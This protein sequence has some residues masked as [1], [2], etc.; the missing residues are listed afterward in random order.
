[1]AD[2]PD[3][4]SQGERARLLPVLA[5]T[6]R[7]R[8]MASVFLSILPQI[9]P[10]AEEVFKTIGQRIGKRDVLETYTEICLKNGD[11]PKDRP[12]GLICI[13]NSK[14]RWTALVEV[15][16][17][18]SELDEAQVTKYLEIAKA[19]GIDA[20]ITISNQFVAR[21]EHSPVAVPKMLL[22]KVALFHWCWAELATHCEVLAYQKAVTDQEQAFL[23]TEL[24]RFLSHAATGVER[25]AQ[26][27]ASWKDLVTAVSNNEKLKKT[28]PAVEE[29]VACWFSEERDL[30]LH[31]SRKLGQR[32][33][34]RIER[35]LADDPSE[36]LRNG[37]HILVEEA[38]LRST[39]L[40]PDAAAAIDICADIKRKTLTVSMKLKAP[41]DRKSTKARVNWFTRSIK[42][43]DPR[44]LVRAHWPGSSASTQEYLAVVREKPEVLQ[45][46]NGD[47]APHSFEVLL[48]E[49]LGK[50]FAGRRTFVE[51][52]ER[53]VPEFYTTVG[54]HLR[55][56]Q[57]QPPK[58]VKVRLE[59]NIDD[60]PG[61]ATNTDP[62]PPEFTEVAVSES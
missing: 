2:L 51:D 39:L 37:V 53:I 59:D 62:L 22:K 56:W 58:P 6:S 60:D 52:L 40:V 26:M 29:A 45:P 57:A 14:A 23:L 11:N 7:E 27:A 38:E 33:T 20:V 5:D 31:I 54:Q 50:R 43:D 24:N 35:K 19:N 49:D 13:S 9:P 47:L 15:K 61:T 10:L 42:V 41:T 12:D 8:R 55:A 1:M 21:A 16:I 3:F 36:R 30:S 25:F 4:V 28:N 48:V 44:V 17:G 32:A 46:S 34:N 18:K